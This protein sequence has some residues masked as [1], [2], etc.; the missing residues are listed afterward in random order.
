LTAVESLHPHQHVGDGALQA[1]K[2]DAL[3]FNFTGRAID[4]AALDQ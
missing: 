3:A 2:F 4:D 1:D